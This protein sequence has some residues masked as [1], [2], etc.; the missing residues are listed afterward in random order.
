MNW[1]EGGV[2]MEMEGTEE[3]GEGGEGKEGREGK[4]DNYAIDN[5]IWCHI[6]N[7]EENEWV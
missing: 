3:R 5:S 2:G 6:R 1:G 7:D 4:E